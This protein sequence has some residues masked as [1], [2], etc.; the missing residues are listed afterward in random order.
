MLWSL[1]HRL[2]EKR[3]DRNMIFIK[4]KA[5]VNSEEET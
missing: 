2:W 1:S 5:L 4:R 3:R